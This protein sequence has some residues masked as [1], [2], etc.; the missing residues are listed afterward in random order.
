MFFL[1]QF[2]SFIEKRKKEV[3]MK[4]CAEVVTMAVKLRFVDCLKPSRCSKSCRRV[5]YGM[6]LN[7]TVVAVVGELLSRWRELRLNRH[8]IQS[9]GPL[10]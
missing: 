8:I 7:L 3:R 2:F 9:H 5:D 4:R 1:L 6:I 10:S